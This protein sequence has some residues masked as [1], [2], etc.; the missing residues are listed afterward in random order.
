MPAGAPTKYKPEYCEQIVHYF[1]V[2]PTVQEK[3]DTGLVIFPTFERFAA[4]INVN[5]ETLLNWGKE[6]PE[7]FESY[8]KCKEMQKAFLIQAGLNGLYAPAAFCFVA[9]N[10]TDMRDKTEQDIH[11]DFPNEI[12]IRD[13]SPSPHLPKEN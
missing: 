12:I 9:K 13:P 10:C 5:F 8:K 6:H 2:T 1:D 4:N 3:A 11:V 7:F